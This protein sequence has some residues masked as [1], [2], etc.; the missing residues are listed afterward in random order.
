ML[1][2]VIIVVVVVTTLV[3]ARHFRGGSMR[4]IPKNGGDQVRVIM[5]RILSAILSRDKLNTILTTFQLAIKSIRK[6]EK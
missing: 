5:G 6:S 3:S 1:K 2:G 4:W